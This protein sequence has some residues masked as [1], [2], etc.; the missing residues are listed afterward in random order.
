MQGPF[1]N[2]NHDVIYINHYWLKSFEEHKKRV[3]VGR[4]DAKIA[5]QLVP[6]EPNYLSKDENHSMDRFIPVLKEKLSI[7]I[8]NR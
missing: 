4:A 7:N 3:S 5:K 1:T 2:I 8:D 6:Y